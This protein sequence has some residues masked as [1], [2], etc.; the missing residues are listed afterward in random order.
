MPIKPLTRLL[1]TQGGRCFFCEQPLSAADAS[2]EHLVASSNGGSNCDENCVACCKPLNQLLGSMSLKEKIQIVL[3]Q[4]GQF[5]CPNGAENEVGETRPQASPKATKAAECNYALLVANLK[6]RGSAKPRTL[7]KLKSMIA[8]L[9]QNKLSDDD[10][11]AL[12]QQLQS[13]HQISIAGSKVT[14]S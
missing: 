14:Y 1:F 13:R 10:V 4:K 2:I 7:V 3:N 6:Q 8:A 12:V 11:Q 5:K 9:F